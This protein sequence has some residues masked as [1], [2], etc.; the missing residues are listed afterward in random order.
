MK[1]LL[2][3]FKV[4]AVL[5]LCMLIGSETFAGKGAIEP[6]KVKVTEISQP[7]RMSF[8][9]VRAFQGGGGGTC[10]QTFCTECTNN[11]IKACGE[12]Q[13]KTVSCTLSTCSCNFDCKAQ[14]E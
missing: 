10:N 13:V 7:S 9:G 8:A 12:G 6:G 4:I 2:T 3:P 11:A 5:A 1:A 14:I